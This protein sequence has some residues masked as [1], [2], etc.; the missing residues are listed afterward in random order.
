M[1]FQQVR[2]FNMFTLLTEAMAL[3]VY[4]SCTYLV[5]QTCRSTWRYFSDV[6]LQVMYT[7]F[8]LLTALVLPYHTP[9]PMHYTIN[10]KSLS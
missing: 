6:F 2:A 10:V 7:A 3:L 1:V 8:F 4:P 5:T 9:L